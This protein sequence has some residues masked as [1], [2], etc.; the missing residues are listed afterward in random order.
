MVALLVEIRCRRGRPKRARTK[1][2]EGVCNKPRTAVRSETGKEA[3]VTAAHR[4]VGN[5]Q[6]R[7]TEVLVGETPRAVVEELALRVRIV[8]EAETVSATKVF[9]KV[10]ALEA[11]A[12][13]VE[14]P[15]GTV[16]AAHGAAVHAAHPAWEV[17]VAVAAGA[18]A[19]GG[20]KES[21]ELHEI[22]TT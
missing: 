8:A 15:A 13:W 11:P 6:V 10:A 16:A 17:A 9:L 14:V 22:T 7:A 21:G 4:E 3:L 1:L 20:E 19:G 5:R 18:V 12:H 2:S